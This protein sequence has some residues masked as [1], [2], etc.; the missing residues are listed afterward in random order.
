MRFKEKPV[1]AS[2]YGGGMLNGKEELA[3]KTFDF[4]K[5][6]MSID[7]EDFLSLR[8]PRELKDGE[9]R[10]KYDQDGDIF[11]FSGYEEIYYQMN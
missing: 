4:L 3:D 2:M 9:W 1:W 7:E 8:G 6:A 5:K 11:E 10:Y